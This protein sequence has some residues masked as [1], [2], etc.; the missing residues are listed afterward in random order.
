MT[1]KENILSKTVK[2]KN[3]KLLRTV[4]DIKN[5]EKIIEIIRNKDL[6]GKTIVETKIYSFNDKLLQH[7]ILPYIIHSEEFTESMAFDVTR[8]AIDMSLDFINDGVYSWDLMPHNYTFNNGNWILY[9]F[10]S[11]DLNPKN[12]KT[13]IRSLFKIS[14]SFFELRKVIERRKLGQLYLNRVKLHDLSKMIKFS[15]WFKFALKLRICQFWCVLKQYKKV[16]KCLNLIL[17]DYEKSFKKKYYSINDSDE[18]KELYNK[19]YDLIS[20]NTLNVFCVGEDSAKWALFKPDIPI[21]KFLYIDDYD[22]CDEVYN[23]ICKKQYKNLSTAVLYPLTSDDD[24][25]LKYEYRAIYDTYTQ[26]RFKSDIVIVMNVNE[27]G[28][29]ENIRECILNLALLSCKS[30]IINLKNDE[31]AFYN[32]INDNLKLYFDRINIYETCSGCLIFA[33]NKKQEN[34]KPNIVCKVYKNNNRGPES[35]KQTKKILELLK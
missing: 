19:I 21:K 27:I 1:E 32:D 26:E 6:F 5:A 7:K 35:K 8:I 14:F 9:D 18:N 4:D 33:N 16:Y 25:S 11:F 17:E 15:D 2:I 34:T 30:L 31:K 22:I 20:D 12:V 10:G 23:Y 28:L 29:I 24:I 13:Q 3:G